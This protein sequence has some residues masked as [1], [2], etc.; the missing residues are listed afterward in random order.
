MLELM[1]GDPGRWRTI[2]HTADLAIEAEAASLERL[3]VV[4]GLALVGLVMGRE[5]GPPERAPGPIADRRRLSLEAP[6]A[7]A[8][9]VDWLRE[10]LHIQ[11]S[12]GLLFWAAEF[13]ELGDTRLVARAEFAAP[14]DAAAIE[15]ELKGVTYHDL[16]LSRRR[17]G[18][19]ARIVFDI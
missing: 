6:D 19:F 10:L 15:R 7:E 11:G 16:E 2:E 5:A 12:D 18:W 17:D 9:L 8:L 3:F 13:E 14:A 4:S 1:S